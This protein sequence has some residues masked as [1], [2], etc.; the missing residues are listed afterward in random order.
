MR[1]LARDDVVE[2]VTANV[3]RILKPE[4]V[5]SLVS[6]S[7]LLQTCRGRRMRV[8]VLAS[9]PHEPAVVNKEGVCGIKHRCDTSRMAGT[10]EAVPER[11][12]CTTCRL[13]G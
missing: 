11:I 9:S 5:F 1:V 10:S 7:G 3:L 13:G 2:L 12:R 8:E 4:R 6:H